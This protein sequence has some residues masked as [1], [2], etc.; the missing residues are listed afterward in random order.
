MFEVLEIQRLGVVLG[1]EDGFALKEFILW[2]EKISTDE[3]IQTTMML[4]RCKENELGK[5]GKSDRRRV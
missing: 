3:Q 2:S 4:E 1:G 5:R